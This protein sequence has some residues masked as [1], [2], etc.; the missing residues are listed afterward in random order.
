[1]IRTIEL[2]GADQGFKSLVP[3]LF[4][5]WATPF[6]G[7]PILAKKHEI[8]YF[9]R[10]LQDQC[11]FLCFCAGKS[12][13]TIGDNVNINIGSL[14]GN[15]SFDKLAQIKI[16]VP[17]PEANLIEVKRSNINTNQKSIILKDIETKL[18]PYHHSSSKL[19][20][21]EFSPIDRAADW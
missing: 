4:E 18:L 1:M 17:E 2:C 11:R 10:F 21:I 8:F 20:S 14:Y 3:L 16:V 6:S 13:K 7:S 5:L 19:S 9:I 12:I 15:T